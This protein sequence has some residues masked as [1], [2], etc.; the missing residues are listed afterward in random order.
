MRFIAAIVAAISM[1]YSIDASAYLGPGLGVGALAA[2]LGVAGG[3]LML[4]VGV[5]WYPIKRV[6]RRLRER[7]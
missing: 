3:I 7:K 5:V 2:V 1:A 4:I 6:M